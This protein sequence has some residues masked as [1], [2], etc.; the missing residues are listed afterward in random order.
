[1]SLGPPPAGMVLSL[2]VKLIPVQ[3]QQ[4]A[5]RLGVRSARN[6]VMRI[7]LPRGTFPQLDLRMRPP[8]RAFDMGILEPVLKL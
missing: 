3:T 7:I 6:Q 4:N 2:S 5:R 1:M 8:Q